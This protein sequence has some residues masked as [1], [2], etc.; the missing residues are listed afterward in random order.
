MRY[1][2]SAMRRSKKE[3]PPSLYLATSSR[4]TSRCSTVLSDWDADDEGFMSSAE[5]LPSGPLSVAIPSVPYCPRR[6][7]LQEVLAGS[8]PP[9]WT[10]SAFMAYLSQ[11]HCLETLE[12]TMDASRYRTH[13]E[14]MDTYPSTPISPAS[15]SC[16]YVAMLWQKLLDAYIAP[17]GPREVNL[18]SDVRDRLMKLPCTPVPPHPSELEQAVKIIFELMDESVLVPFLNSVTPSQTSTTPWTSSDEIPQTAVSSQGSHDERSSSPAQSRNRRDC[19]PPGSGSGTE[20]V[21]STTSPVPRHQS[22]LTAALNRSAG[23]RISAYFSSI[24]SSPE[25]QEAGLTDDSASSP[26]NS[27][28]E[29]MTPPTTPPTSDTGFQGVSPG[30]SP[31]NS[32]SEGNGWKKMGQKLGWKKSKSGS[33]TNGSTSSKRY[34]GGREVNTEEDSA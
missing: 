34:P 33:S 27:G 17:N 14:I 8:A 30:T 13:Y 16:E 26:S 29:P 6:P 31:K 25:M 15:E 3:K 24:S 7:T 9:P 19:S 32:R 28:L 1:L 20:T 5:F 21:N 22:H 11:N 10:L 18:P 2:R 4:E 12:F 23:G